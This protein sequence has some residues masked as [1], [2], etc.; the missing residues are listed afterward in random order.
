MD[1]QNV[2]VQ[3]TMEAEQPAPETTGDDWDDIDLT[4]V[5]DNDPDGEETPEEAPAEETAPEEAPEAEAEEGPEAADRPEP[6]TFTLKH[7]DEVRTV[8][9]DEVVALAQKGLDYDRIR[10]QRDQAAGENAR[11]KELEGFLQELAA[12]SGMSV[13]DLMD[14]T[15]ANL[16]ADREG[17]DRSV[18]LQRVKLD[19]DR[20][21]LEAEKAARNRQTEAE[22][23]QTAE[24][25]RRKESIDRFIAAHKDLPADQIPQ[26]V[27]DAF[28]KG[29]DLS[30]AYAAH[31]A[32]TLRGKVA[33]LEKALEA[34]RQ[35]AANRARST[36]SQSTAGS[37]GD[38]EDI[39][40]K[41]WYDG[42]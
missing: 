38:K 41:L 13:E 15:R 5:T 9:R 18:A 10:E 22:R 19:R 26:S 1:E 34:E 3:E 39:Y 31:E 12:P 6:E 20:K 16:L 7:L 21:A 27:W 24:E 17:I 14:T 23:A 37:S 42:T 33:E 8:G 2:N 25:R 40:D 4:D 30:D 28:A 35:N 11:L 32:E 29:K 36:G